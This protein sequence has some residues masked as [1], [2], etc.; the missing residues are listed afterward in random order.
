VIGPNVVIGPG[1]VVEEG[2]RIKNSVVLEKAKIG[3]YSYVDGSIIGWRSKVG[4]WNRLENLSIL[5][6]EVSLADEI[7][8]NGAIVLPN[9]SVKNSIT[10][11]GTILLC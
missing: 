11:P 1:V 4:K 10:V 9:V 3:S 2:A 7:N 8:L 6:E 5:G